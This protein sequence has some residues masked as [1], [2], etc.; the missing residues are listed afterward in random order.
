MKQFAKLNW[1]NGKTAKRAVPNK[2]APGRSFEH[3]EALRINKNVTEALAQ[4]AQTEHEAVMVGD[5]S[6]LPD[7]SPELEP[8]PAA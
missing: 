6:P 8:Q 4:V 5:F 2:N 7:F 1:L 3:T